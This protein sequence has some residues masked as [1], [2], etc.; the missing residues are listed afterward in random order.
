MWLTMG[1]ANLQKRA[2][3]LNYVEVTV[4]AVGRL[5][6][7]LPI[8]WGLRLGFSIIE[9]YC[10]SKFPDQR[11]YQRARTTKNQSVRVRVRVCKQGSSIAS[12]LLQGCRR[13]A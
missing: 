1:N 7:L 13:T 3:T 4:F 12:L 10:C 6:G 9:I 8:D 2:T 11:E 5:D